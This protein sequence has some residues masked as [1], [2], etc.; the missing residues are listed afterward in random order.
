[1]TNE[2]YLPRLLLAAACVMSLPAFAAEAP[3]VNMD[4]P[5]AGMTEFKQGDKMPDSYKRKELALQ[6]WHKRHL[7]APSENEQWVQIQDK[8]VLVNIPGGTAKTIVN[9]SDM[10]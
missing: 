5:G 2:K 4:R 3:S 7:A 10:K 6:D 8:Y 1:M 9:K